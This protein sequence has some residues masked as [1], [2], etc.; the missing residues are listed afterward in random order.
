MKELVFEKEESI[1]GITVYK[2]FFGIECLCR[3]EEIGQN[4]QR[5]TDGRSVAYTKAQA[6]YDE[7]HERKK[8]GYPKVEILASTKFP[9]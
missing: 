3:E 9:D 4:A 6:K 2:I 7:F 8:A 1:T 5:C